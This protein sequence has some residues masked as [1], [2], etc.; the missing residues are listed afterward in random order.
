M[1]GLESEAIPLDNIAVTQPDIGDKF[2]VCA[3]F[4]AWRTVLPVRSK[5]VDGSASPLLQ[6][7]RCRRMIAVRMRDKNMGDLF[8]VKRI[9]E[10]LQM[11]RVVRA[12]INHCNLMR[13][14]DGDARAFESERARI[15]CQ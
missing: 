9:P 12:R 3:F 14:H 5:S 11:R 1:H 6:V 2:A 10:R 15:R 8:A 4:N 13:S 7:F